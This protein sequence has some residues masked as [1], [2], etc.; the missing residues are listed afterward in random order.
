MRFF[1]DLH[2]HSCLSP[3]GDT[4]MTP[5]NI[6][7]MAK[8]KGLDI[9]ALTDHNSSKN[10]PAL[11]KAAERAG[12]LAL[13]G[14]ELCTAEE[15]HVVCLFPNLD[16]A[17]EFDKMVEKSLP[18]I[19]NNPDIFGEQIIMDG[20]D[21]ITGTYPTLLTTAS[22]IGLDEA[23]NLAGR[24]GGVAVPAHIDRP[25][26][27]VISVL[28]DVPGEGFSAYEISGL[29]CVDTL[30][31]RYPAISGKTIL[32]NSDAHYLSDINE[33]GPWLELG[34]LSPEN[35]IGALLNGCQW[36]F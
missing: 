10:C 33:T 5:N 12:V 34:F 22:S 7:N 6:V 32:I 24:F 20:D 36:G 8:L 18:D 14:M 27:S 29:N 9:I 17:L 26:F 28:G 13:P 3:C 4:D 15:C 23:A 25:S 21:T 1:Y 19:K 2:I 16:A 30:S 35:V 11:L 31:Q